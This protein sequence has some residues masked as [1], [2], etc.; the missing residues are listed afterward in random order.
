MRAANVVKLPLP[1]QSNDVK[2]ETA[3]NVM[4][5]AMQGMH[6]RGQRLQETSD[7]AEKLRDA[8]TDFNKMTKELVA[9]QKRSGW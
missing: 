9:R 7:R 8:A 6:E 3:Q 5:E 2:R 1:T 4:A